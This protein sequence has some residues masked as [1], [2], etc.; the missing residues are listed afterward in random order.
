MPE[1][2]SAENL[3]T[4]LADA[5][6]SVASA[7]EGLSSSTEDGRPVQASLSNWDYRDDI[8]L[9]LKTDPTNASC[10]DAACVLQ[11]TGLSADSRVI[12]S[13]WRDR[14]ECLAVLSID[15]QDIRW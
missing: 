11:G 1:D 5:L 13:P 7:S 2:L 9:L 6:D 15:P 8:R 3:A 14:V 10:P 12:A 4:R